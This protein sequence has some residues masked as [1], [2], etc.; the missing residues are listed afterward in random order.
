MEKHSSFCAPEVDVTKVKHSQKCT[1]FKYV[2]HSKKTYDINSVK[3]KKK[4]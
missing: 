2:W 4:I 3:R 1:Q